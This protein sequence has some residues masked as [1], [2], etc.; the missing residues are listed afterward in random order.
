[1]PPM[2]TTDS[3]APTTSTPRGP[4]Y[5]DVAHEPDARQHDRDD[6]DLEQRTP[7]RHDR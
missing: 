2:P 5:G 6:D 4:V 1:M 7:T 3:T